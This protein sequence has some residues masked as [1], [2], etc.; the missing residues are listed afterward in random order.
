MR[1][2]YKLLSYMDHSSNRGRGEVA[3]VKNLIPQVFVL[4]PVNIS[5]Y[6]NFYQ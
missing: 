1:K 3:T 4:F 2:N 5:I 6:K